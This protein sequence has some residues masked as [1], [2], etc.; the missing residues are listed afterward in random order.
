MARFSKKVRSQALVKKKSASKSERS[1]KET[2][3]NDNNKERYHGVV[4]ALVNFHNTTLKRS[5]RSFELNWE[6]A[7]AGVT[8][9]L[10]DVCYIRTS[11]IA[12]CS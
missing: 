1:M 6:Q 7:Y 2:F 9:I 12:K 3:L 4:S 11:D 10:P 5:T 8:P